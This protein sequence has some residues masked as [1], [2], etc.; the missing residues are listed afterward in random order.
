[1]GDEYFEEEFFHP[2][3]EVEETF[4]EGVYIN[5][6]RHTRWGLEAVAPYSR[7]VAQRIGNDQSMQIAPVNFAASLVMAGNVDS[8]TI[9][10]GVPSDWP[11]A[12]LGV[13]TNDNFSIKARIASATFYDFAY[14]AISIPVGN[15][16]DAVG[17]FVGLFTGDVILRCS[18]WSSWYTIAY[19][20]AD[21]SVYYDDDSGY[22]DKSD[23]DWSKWF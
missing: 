13:E 22:V 12:G 16:A 11:A 23:P 9:I 14:L 3:T 20:T 7:V 10:G 18:D 21:D 19:N 17:D 2:T 15:N 6:Y 8:Q 4:N 5:S 1:M